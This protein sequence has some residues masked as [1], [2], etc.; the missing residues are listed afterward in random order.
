MS[1]ADWADFTA[2]PW[3]TT[4]IRRPGGSPPLDPGAAYAVVRAAVEPSRHGVLFFTVPEVRFHRPQG[5]VGGPGG[6]LP[7]PEDGTLTEYLRR[8]ADEPVLLTVREPLVIDFPLWSTVRRL[9][10]P[11]WKRVGVPVVAV[12]SEL[13]VSD[14]L[15]HKVRTDGYH[16]LLWVLQ[17]RLKVELAGGESLDGQAGDLLSWPAQAAEMTGDECL[18]LRLLVPVDS[19]LA[20]RSVSDLLL[21]RLQ[22]QRGVEETP[23]LPR[24][25]KG[26]PGLP[27]APLA[28]TAERLT[29]LSTHAEVERSLRVQWTKR[30]SAAALE[31]A[32]APSRSEVLIGDRLVAAAPV[33]RMP[34]G[35][36]WLW[37]ANGHAFTVG[38]QGGDDLLDRLRAGPVEV[39]NDH[40][41]PLLRRLYSLRAVE[42]VG[43]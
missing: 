2:L 14:R 22:H 36:G 35:E 29:R 9:V 41:L 12:Q 20:S 13:V 5:R 4:P 27:M 10:E 8:V 25:G 33:I 43:R 15:G 17:G 1:T 23:Y 24:R 18:W 6:L 28:E 26:E 38:G 39:R 30:V 40:Y 32:P 16:S 21:P 3:E 37:A 42:V 11:L 7:G 34:D 31:P 19:V